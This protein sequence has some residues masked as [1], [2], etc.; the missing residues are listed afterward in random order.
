MRWAWGRSGAVSWPGLSPAGDC[1]KLVMGGKCQFGNILFCFVDTPTVSGTLLPAVFRQG[2]ITFSMISLCYCHF[3]TSIY[4]KCLHLP[5]LFAPCFTPSFRPLK[6][7]LQLVYSPVLVLFLVFVCVQALSPSLYFLLLV[8]P[9]CLILSA[10]RAR[11][12]TLRRCA[13]RHWLY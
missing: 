11:N 8:P 12:G 6:I 9:R 1:H 4:T 7:F 13:K 3:S 5:F 10:S 2:L